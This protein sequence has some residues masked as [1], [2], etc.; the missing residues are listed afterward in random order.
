MVKGNT[1]RVVVVKSPDEKLFEQAIF[2]LREDALSGGGVSDSELLRQ[3][4]EA[5]RNSDAKRPVRLQ[6]L[7]WFLCGVGSCSLLWALAAVIS[8]P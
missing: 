6:R 2:L 1:R 5:C 8:H 4:R 3:A 7:M